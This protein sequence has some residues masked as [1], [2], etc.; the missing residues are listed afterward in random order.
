MERY[1]EGRERRRLRLVFGLRQIRGMNKWT[2][3]MMAVALIQPVFM[4]FSRPIFPIT[5]STDMDTV[6][7]IWNV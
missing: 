1:Q 5:V 7:P 6:L 3:L 4:Q 2:E